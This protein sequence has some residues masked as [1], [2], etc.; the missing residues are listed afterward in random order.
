[1]D[2]LIS[3]V[4]KNLL[5]L[6]TATYAYGYDAVGNRNSDTVNGVV[7]SAVFNDA[8]QLTSRDGVTYGYD[9]NG[10]QTGSTAGAAFAY[11]GADQTTT[12]TKAG[13]SPLAATYAGASQFERT[14][15]GPTTFTN[16]LLGVT[17]ASESGATTRDP[18]GGLVGLRSPSGPSY[19]LFDGL[20]SVVAVTGANGSVT[21]TPTPTIPTG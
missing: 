21:N 19:F 8:D 7:T 11:N 14:S 12:L 9:D 1:L 17:A 10:N 5:G 6:T 18:G 2:R 15:A 4:T 20:G 13:G 16:S 3:A